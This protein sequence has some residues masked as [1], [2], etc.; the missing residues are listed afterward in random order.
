MLFPSRGILERSFFANFG[1]VNVFPSNTVVAIG[2][3]L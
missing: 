2:G 3:D 1:E